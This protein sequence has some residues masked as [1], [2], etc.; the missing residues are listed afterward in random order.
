MWQA[1]VVP[2]PQDPRRLGHPRGAGAVLRPRRLRQHR[3]RPHRR[4]RHHQAGAAQ[5]QVR[6]FKYFFSH[7]IFSAAPWSPT[8]CC[9]GRIP[10]TRAR[11]SSR[12]CWGCSTVRCPASTA[13]SPST[14]SRSVLEIHIYFTVLPKV[15]ISLHHSLVTFYLWCSQLPTTLPLSLRPVAIDCNLLL[16]FSVWR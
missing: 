4:H 1:E 5:R 14:T 13:S 11:T 10:G 16:C 2:G 15:F 7:Q 3:G 12:A 8:S 6:H 9:Y